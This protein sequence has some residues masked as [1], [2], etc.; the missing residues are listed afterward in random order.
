MIGLL[1]WLITNNGDDIENRKKV[2]KK[3]FSKY[4]N[5]QV[6]QYCCLTTRFRRTR[7][8][9]GRNNETIH[10][11]FVPRAFRDVD[12]Q[13]TTPEPHGVVQVFFVLGQFRHKVGRP[14]HRSVRFV[15]V[16]VVRIDGRN[17][18]IANPHAHR[19][20]FSQ[21]S[22]NAGVHQHP[23]SFSIVHQLTEVHHVDFVQLQFLAA[24]QRVR[25]RNALFQSLQR[26]SR[27][28]SLNTTNMSEVYVRSGY[29][30]WAQ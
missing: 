1:G 24:V 16:K 4:T 22:S 5:Y 6:C 13:R 12:V 28:R 7:T 10:F 30:Q 14:R 26:S 29:E 3:I 15:V 17:V 25:H 2:K 9:T 20:Q 11:Y 21:T 19:D 8:T 23:I 27:G 18:S